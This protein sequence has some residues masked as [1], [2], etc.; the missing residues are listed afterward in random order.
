M[1]GLV[2]AVL[3]Q[4][5][6]QH[7]L[8]E[9]IESIIKWPFISEILIRDNSKCK[10]IMCSARYELAKKATNDIIYTQDD[11]CIIG[12]MDKLYKEF[13]KDQTTMVT[14][15]I[16]GYLDV[17][18]ENI[19]G[20]KQMGLMGWGA[21]FKK[22]WIKNLDKYTDVH[23]KDDCFIRE[24]DRIFSILLNKRHK[25]L[26]AN[27]KLFNTLEEDKKIALSFQPDHLHYKKISIER[28]LAL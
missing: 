25:I 13:L 16:Q 9:I 12:D 14:G 27:I 10:N 19:Y 18:D 23:G 4:W 5:K 20:D 2:T 8:P 11:D 26:L 24:S 21:F 22:E 3:V 15:G 28:A 17:I 7:Y 1:A 6:R